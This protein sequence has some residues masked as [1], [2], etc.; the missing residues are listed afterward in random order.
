[1]AQHVAVRGLSAAPMMVSRSA[2]VCPGC[3]QRCAKLPAVFVK[4]A[5]VAA[6]QDKDRLLPR[7]QSFDSVPDDA[8]HVSRLHWWPRKAVD[9]YAQVYVSSALAVSRDALRVV[10]QTIRSWHFQLKG[11]KSLVDLSRTFDPVLR[12]RMN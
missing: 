7:R 4:G 5:G 10:R 11:D 2:G 3:S 9:K 12:G 1:V 6:R 8:V